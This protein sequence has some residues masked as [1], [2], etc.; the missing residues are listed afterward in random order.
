M[1]PDTPTP[2]LTPPAEAADAPANLAA[3]IESTDAPAPTPPNDAEPTAVTVA[4][5]AAPDALAAPEAPDAAD[6]SDAADIAHAA[7]TAAVDATPASTAPA[8]PPD[9][10]PA[11]CADRLADLFPAL[12]GA[13]RAL[14]IKLRIQAD[15]QQRAPGV[16]NK[17]SLS[18]FLHRA[19]TSTAYIRALAQMPQRLDLDGAPAGEVAEEHR[20]AATAELERRRVIVEARRATERDAQRQA[21]AEARRAQSAQGAPQPQAAAADGSATPDTQTPRPP[22]P[23]RPPRAP[24]PPRQDAAPRRDGPPRQQDPRPPRDPQ[25]APQGPEGHEGRDGRDARDPRARRDPR[26]PRAPMA[27]PPPSGDASLAAPV[28]MATAA[29]AATAPAVVYSA[30]ELEA[31]RERGALLR[32]WESSTLTRANFCVL[33]RVAEN[34]LDAQLELARKEQ[35]DRP[36]PPRAAPQA[37]RQEWRADGPRRDGPRDGP[38]NGPRRSGG[39]S[40]GPR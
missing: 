23:P 24:R 14:P 20:V 3:A 17:K 2:E 31:R 11:V 13:G 21:A 26:P 22:S 25:S 1:I 37:P 29:P 18:I 9:M 7:D 10:S 27:A 39:P 34:T 32:A 5:D 8:G 36:P 40:R 6:V 33:K 30:A 12:F 19:T 35:G 28:A 15:I 16:F 4:A 38:G